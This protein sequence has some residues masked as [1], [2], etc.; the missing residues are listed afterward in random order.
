MK[1]LIA[2]SEAL[3]PQD[4]EWIEHH[5]AVIDPPPLT[6]AQRVNWEGISLIRE[7]LM[8]HDAFAH[9]R[10]E[11]PWLVELDSPP[12]NQL[13]T[14]FLELGEHALQG[15][16]S[17]FLSLTELAEH[18]SNALIAQDEDDQSFLIRSYA[19]HVLPVLH[20]CKDRPWHA[21]LFGPI[22]QWWVPSP[23]GLQQYSGHGLTTPPEF[24][25]IQLDGALSDQL[26]VDQLALAMLHELQSNTPEVFV[27]TCHG[28]QLDQVTRALQ[29]ARDSGL[30]RI[31]DQ[32]L[33]ATLYLLEGHPLNK[34]RHWPTTLQLVE[35]QQHELGHVLT[36]LRQA[37]S[38]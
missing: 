25:P 8:Q 7:S 20:G 4:R 3:Q 15:W 23:S 9:L 37:G 17:S 38:A 24:S 12:S 33:F 35:E 31:D 6:A 27:S 19:S 14:P 32:R 21:W 30:T 2:A 10:E 26:A 13:D 36:S 5:Y 28:E 34:Y 1:N 22:N 11:G 18:L 16:C 29:S